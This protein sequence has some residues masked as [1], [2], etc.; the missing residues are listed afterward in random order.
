M[1]SAFLPVSP[2][3]TTKLGILWNILFLSN[4]FLTLRKHARFDQFR[5][6]PTPYLVTNSSPKDCRRVGLRSIKNYPG[7]S[8]PSHGSKKRAPKYFNLLSS[9]NHIAPLTQTRVC[10]HCHNMAVLPVFS[11]NLGLSD[12]LEG[13]SRGYPSFHF[14]YFLIA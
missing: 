3:L 9:C 13:I 14:Y 7:S 10:E 6:A 4:Y 2:K 1:A 8:G 5:A 11:F 12:N